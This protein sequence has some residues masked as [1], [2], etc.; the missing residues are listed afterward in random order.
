VSLL[1]REAEALLKAA[2]NRA[3]IAS[4]RMIAFARTCLEGSAVGRLALAVLDGGV[5]APRR[6]IELAKVVLNQAA[7]TNPAEPAIQAKTKGGQ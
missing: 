7:N 4:A 1:A 3:P 5:F 2:A 6:A